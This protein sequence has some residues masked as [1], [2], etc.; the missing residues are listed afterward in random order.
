M[1]KAAESEHDNAWG[2]SIYTLMFLAKEG[3]VGYAVS[4]RTRL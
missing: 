3:E 2:N 1:F 4:V